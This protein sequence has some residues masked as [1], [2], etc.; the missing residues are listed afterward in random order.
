MLRSESAVS[1][2]PR[3]SIVLLSMESEHNIHPLQDVIPHAYVDLWSYIWGSERSG[4][5]LW[6]VGPSE[7]WLVATL[8]DE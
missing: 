6:D 8:D 3:T 4:M 2:T 5:A 1:L 7:A